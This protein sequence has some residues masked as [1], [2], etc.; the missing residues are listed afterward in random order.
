MVGSKR[1]ELTEP[2]ELGKEDIEKLLQV[3]EVP[4]RELRRLLELHKRGQL[5]EQY[6]NKTYVSS[7]LTSI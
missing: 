1:P 7:P 4:V 6:R 3:G 5:Y 2:F